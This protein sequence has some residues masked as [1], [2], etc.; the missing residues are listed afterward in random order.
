MIYPIN[1]TRTDWFRLA[2]NDLLRQRRVTCLIVPGGKV[3][4]AVVL[5]MLT[6]LGRLHVVAETDGPGCGVRRCSSEQYSAFCILS[7]GIFASLI[8]EVMKKEPYL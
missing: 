2:D 5:H 8:M 7:S 3:N 1:C 6:F 4:D